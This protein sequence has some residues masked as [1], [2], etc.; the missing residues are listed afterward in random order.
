VSQCQCDRR[1]PFWQ[2]PFGQPIDPTTGLIG[3]LDADD[4]V[5]DTIEGSSADWAWVGGAQKLYEHQGSI[6]T[7][8]MGARQYVA[9][10]GRFL[11]VDPV[12]GGVTNSYDYPADPINRFDLSGESTC[13]SGFKVG[14]C[15]KRVHL[16]G[17]V[18]AGFHPGP[19]Y[20]NESSRR[21]SIGARGAFKQFPYPP[22]YFTSAELWYDENAR[23]FVVSA[24]FDGTYSN[25]G[26]AELAWEELVNALGPTID[27]PSVRQQFDC[28]VLGSGILA[29]RNDTSFDL[30]LSRP[31]N[32]AWLVTGGFQ[33]IIHPGDLC[34]W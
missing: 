11:E 3:T 8:E 29:I 16:R 12:D 4:A 27:T 24:K 19:K 25:M 17:A 23:T 1:L 28:H 33:S 18:K 32:P 9:A 5:A 6:A 15:P 21:A 22:V 30:E 31:S 14:G 26:K 2:Y 34:N 20:A 13:P 10:L 7:I